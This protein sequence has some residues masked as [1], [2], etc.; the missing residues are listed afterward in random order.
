[1]IHQT[2]ALFSTQQLVLG[3][4]GTNFDD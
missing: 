1:V 2:F 3:V 4:S